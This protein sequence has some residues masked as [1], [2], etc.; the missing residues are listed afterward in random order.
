[1]LIYVQLI[2]RDIE[3][4]ADRGITARVAQA[5]W[6]AICSR[7]QA[8]FRAGR[9]ESGALAGI[10]EVAALLARHFPAHDANPNELSDK[11]VML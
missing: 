11:P 5:E 4:V 6:N 8:E 3:I 2:D 9:F 7:M 1:M 10:S